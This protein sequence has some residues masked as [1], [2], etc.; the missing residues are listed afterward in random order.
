[1]SKRNR[2]RR[3]LSLV[4]LLSVCC[5]A[6][7][8]TIAGG[9]AD[10]YFEIEVIDAETRRGI[11][12]VE[13]TTVDEV[14]YWTDNAGRIAYFEPGHAG[15]TI[16][17]HVRAFGYNV[18][19]DGFGFQGVRLQIAPGQAA[20]I[21]L[22]RINLAERLYRCTGQGLYRDSVLLGRST[23][24]REPL[25]AGMVA[26]QDSIFS[27]PYRDQLYWF[28][29]DTLRLSYPL[30]HFRMAGAVSQWPGRG[31]L[32][33]ALGV[34]Y[35]YFVNE[36]GFSRPMAELPAKEGVVWL[37]GIATVADD[38][39]S[40][41]MVARFTRRPGLADAYEQGMMKFNDDR[42]MF[43]RVTNLSTQESWRF[44]RDHPIEV[45]DGDTRYL[46]C[47]NPFPVTRVKRTLAAVLDPQAYE[48]WTCAEPGTDPEKSRPNRDAQGKL[49]W[50]WHKGPPVTQQIENR[51]IKR[52][53]IKPHEARFLPVDAQQ[54]ARRVQMH[55][56]T[57][58]WNPYRNRWVMVAIELAGDRQAPSYLGEVWYSEAESP[59]GPWSTAIKIVTHNKQ[60]FYN[61]CHHDVFD[62]QGGR[63]IY[64]EGT[65]CN[66]F[67]SSPP[68]P[69]YNYNQMMYRL[70][71]DRPELQQA[72][73]H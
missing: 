9:D 35:E 62:Q 5:A 40:D 65:Y 58:R 55:S 25:G 10:R 67:T 51:W 73:P 46:V 69:R 22:Q 17:F 33:P 26:G 44:L 31:G 61:P 70:D 15:Q 52:G 21:E 72:F 3:V 41:V 34:D 13:L 36:D 12:L 45:A 53:E 8:Q 32:D 28:W 18:P 43:E 42:Q 1:M 66:T 24:L 14:P 2:D 50:Q 57:T 49:I 39:I 37:D 54:P 56:G 7:A 60:S 19:K 4:V 29:G 71:L 27:V 47:G 20:Q 59:Q 30:G 63:I 11:P 48:S 64:F 68:T 23:P 38:Q 6:R 16:F